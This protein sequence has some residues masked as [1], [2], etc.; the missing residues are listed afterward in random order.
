MTVFRTLLREKSLTVSCFAICLKHLTK[1][2]ISCCYIK[3]KA[4]GTK[5]KLIRWFENSIY[6]RKQKVKLNKVSSLPC[7]VLAGVPQVS[8]LGHL[9][10][11]IH[12]NDIASN[13]TSL[14]RLFGDDTCTSF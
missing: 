13:L 11:I 14:C 2:G 12:I 3:L 8:V 10:F 6:E 5:G 1:F 7:K 4:H 9:L